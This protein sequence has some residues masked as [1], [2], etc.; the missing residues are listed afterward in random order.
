MVLNH[1]FRKPEGGGK[2]YFWPTRSTSSRRQGRHRRRHAEEDGTP[3]TTGTTM[4][5][6]KNNGV[7]PQA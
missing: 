7:D 4:S 3:S 5:K 2:D 1:I 6:S